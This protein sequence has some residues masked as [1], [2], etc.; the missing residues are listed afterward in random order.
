MMCN[1]T[2]DLRVGFGMAMESFL[3]SSSSG[4]SES[5][6]EVELNGL[7]GRARSLVPPTAATFSFDN[8]PGV[9]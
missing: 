3:P 5:T 9:G 2:Y 4:S 6:L 7:V 1:N 8:L